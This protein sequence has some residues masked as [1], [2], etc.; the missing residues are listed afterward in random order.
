MDKKTEARSLSQSP[1]CVAPDQGC[2]GM[3]MVHPISLLSLAVFL[4]VEGCSRV[5][6]THSLNLSPA[7]SRL[8]RGFETAAY[9]AQTPPSKSTVVRS[10]QGQLFWSVPVPHVH[11]KPSSGGT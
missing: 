9:P 5:S 3:Q 2:K 8:P 10:P 6:R 4:L 11:T 7:L 1:H